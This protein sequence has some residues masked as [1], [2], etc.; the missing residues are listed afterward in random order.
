MSVAFTVDWMWIAVGVS[1]V[2]GVVLGVIGT[3]LWIASQM[4][5]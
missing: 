2:A 3:F 1:I 4:R 5:L